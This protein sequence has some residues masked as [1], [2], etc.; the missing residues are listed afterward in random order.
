MSDIAGRRTGIHGPTERFF[1]VRGTRAAKPNQPTN[2]S[3][4]SRIKISDRSIEA[5]EECATRKSSAKNHARSR[6]CRLEDFADVA[7]VET[8]GDGDAQPELAREPSR[9]A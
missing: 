7:I 8:P 1:F 5:N 6:G 4:Q 3:T 2:Q 9:V